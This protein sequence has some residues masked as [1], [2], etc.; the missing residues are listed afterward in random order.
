MVNQVCNEFCYQAFEE[1]KNKLSSPSVLRFSKSNK[2]FEVHTDASDFA[3][4]GIL[5]QDGRPIAHESKR[6]NGCQRRWS[7]H[8]KELFA[9]VHF[10]KTWQH[11]LGLNKTNV[12]MD[13]VSLST[14]GAN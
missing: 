3:I 6:L 14:Y 4:R 9:V 2:P 12:Y 7:I 11:Y 5:I 13:N 8:E 1:L 10:L